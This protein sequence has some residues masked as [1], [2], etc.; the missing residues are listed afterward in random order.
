MLITLRRWILLSLVVLCSGLGIF[1]ISPVQAGD[2][3]SDVATPL[4]SEWGYG[5]ERAYDF[6]IDD[7]GDLW[8]NV[9]KLFFPDASADNQIWKLLRN[10]LVWVL[11]LLFIYTG[12]QIL[13]NADK[14]EEVNKQ[15]LN[16]IFI[17][18]G[19]LLIFLS[20]WILDTLLNI[21]DI[22][23]V[24]GTQDNTLISKFE[25]AML[26]VLWILK[27][28]AFFLAIVM[29]AYNGIKM[30]YA[31]G[32][33]DKVKVAGQWVLNVVLALL[34][35]KIVDYLYYI[36]SQQNFASAAS[37]LI[38]QVTRV[39]GYVLWVWLVL[40]IIYAGYTMIT[41]Q[42]ND[43]RIGQ[44]KAMIKTVAIVWLVVLLFLLVIYQLFN[45]IL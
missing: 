26:L 18:I 3:R 38:V 30:L 44:A 41:W 5:D 33:A 36:T 15:L 29:V 24:F 34:F 27:G 43:E 40:W 35:I 22:D 11:V 31:T 14:A 13:F 42:G 6:G 19:A 4:L 8:D 10:I 2:F 32:A 39:L 21:R 37:E 25:S 45:D 17:I 9:R 20:V 1:V 28:L 12:A 23:G 7:E 16:L